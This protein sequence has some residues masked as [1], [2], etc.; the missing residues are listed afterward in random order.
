MRSA[1]RRADAAKR[2]PV[3]TGEFAPEYILEYTR[4]LPRDLVALL[5]EIQ[6]VHQGSGP[7]PGPAVKEGVMN[8]CEQYFQGEIFNNLAGVLP[9]S[10]QAP[11]KVAAF[12]D[13]M[14]TVQSRFF[15]FDEVQADLDGQ[16]TSDETTSLLRQMFE[17]GA[18]GV[19]T[20]SETAT[21]TDFIYRNV[22][23]AG[24]TKRHGFVLHNALTRAWNRPWR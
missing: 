20:R 12:R 5:G 13:A 2:K 14:R 4:F 10:P 15:S 16:L 6:K 18:I 22:G 9:Q 21:H 19:T 7:V 23:G 11:R 17:V 1:P 3:Q 8:Y 24:F